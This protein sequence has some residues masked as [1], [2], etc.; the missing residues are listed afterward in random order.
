MYTSHRGPCRT[1]FCGA[2]P[3]IAAPNLFHQRPSMWYTNCIYGIS[4]STPTKHR[5]PGAPSSLYRDAKRIFCEHLLHRVVARRG[6]SAPLS[7][8]HAFRNRPT[9]GHS[10]VRAAIFEC[11]RRKYHVHE[12]HNIQRFFQSGLILLAMVLANRSA[13]EDMRPGTMPLQS[14]LL[15]QALYTDVKIALGAVCLKAFDPS[16]VQSIRFCGK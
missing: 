12:K 11:P 1:C 5:Q 13:T 3:H 15:L 14:D 2:M 16:F 4:G 7:G 10:A 8:P 6:V 9:A